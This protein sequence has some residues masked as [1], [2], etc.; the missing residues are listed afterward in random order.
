MSS[1]NDLSGQQHGR[2]GGTVTKFMDG[3]APGSPLD[4][5][6]ADEIARL[7]Y[8]PD[9]TRLEAGETYIDVNQLD[10]GP[11]SGSDEDVASDGS[12]IV[13]KNELDPELWARL[14]G[15]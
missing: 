8:L 3:T 6:N 11:F 14:T 15:G 9:G 1:E 13:A 5:L 7:P 10:A 2:M 12:R 4:A